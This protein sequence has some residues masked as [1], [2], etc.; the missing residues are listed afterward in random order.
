MPIEP[1]MDDENAEVVHCNDIASG[2]DLGNMLDK[3][4]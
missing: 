2:M 3:L 1:Q 4:V